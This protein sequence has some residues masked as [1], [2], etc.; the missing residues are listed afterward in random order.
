M[1]IA[2]LTASEQVYAQTFNQTKGSDDTFKPHW[3]MQVQGGVAHTVGEAN[4]KKLISPAAVLSLGYR[5][6][7]LWGVRVG[8]GG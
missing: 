5:F 8:V 7:P 6:S 1:P 3:Y 2:A 4:F